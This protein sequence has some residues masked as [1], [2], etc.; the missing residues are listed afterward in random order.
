MKKIINIKHCVCLE[1]VEKYLSA[2]S[3]LLS[4]ET[5]NKKTQEIEINI[6]ATPSKLTYDFVI[7]INLTDMKE[8]EIANKEDT[9][10]SSSIIRRL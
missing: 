8:E 9:P 4:N 6:K 7:T 3:E 5:F 10:L 1:T 2:F